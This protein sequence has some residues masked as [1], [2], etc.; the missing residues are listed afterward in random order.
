M[1]WGGGGGG[2]RRRWR[3]HGGG[4][5]ARRNE[6]KHKKYHIIISNPNSSPSIMAT[7]EDSIEWNAGLWISKIQLSELF[8]KK[9]VKVCI[10]LG[11]RTT[12][13]FCSFVCV[14]PSSTI[15]AVSVC[16]RRLHIFQTVQ[17]ETSAERIFFY[18]L[19]CF[20]RPSKSFPTRHVS[21]GRLGTSLRS[22]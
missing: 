3:H 9:L 10:L 18:I 6:K 19:V 4:E 5:T 13:I 16:F 14:H 15:A 22:R 7:K 20:R 1:W 11:I 21:M 12:K 8:Q 17:N 2:R